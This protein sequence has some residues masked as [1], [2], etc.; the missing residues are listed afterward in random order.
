VV[1]FF[2]HARINDFLKQKHLETHAISDRSRVYEIWK[3]SRKRFMQGENVPFVV[4]PSH[5]PDSHF[6]TVV[7][8]PSAKLQFESSFSYPLVALERYRIAPPVDDNNASTRF[9]VTLNCAYQIHLGPCLDVGGWFSA[10]WLKLTGEHFFKT[11]SSDVSN[12]IMGYVF[13]GQNRLK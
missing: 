7:R 4:P 8:G 3:S 6:K 5:P 9:P 11:L 13:F 2:G 1:P 10:E 12:G